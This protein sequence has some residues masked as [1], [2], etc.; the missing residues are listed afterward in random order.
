LII[1]YHS[2]GIIPDN[3]QINGIVV[4]RCNKDELYNRLKNENYSLNKIEQYIQ[5]EVF[6]VC[7]NEAREAFDETIVCQLNNTT[8][9]DLKKNIEYL[10]KWI[11]QWPIFSTME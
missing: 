6:Q 5:S 1:D 3:N 7:L 11:D 8:D 9:E 2:P 10:I 4:L